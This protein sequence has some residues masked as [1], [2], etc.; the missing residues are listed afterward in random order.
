MPPEKVEKI[1]YHVLVASVAVALITAAVGLTLLYTTSP[2]A[3]KEAKYEG[4]SPAIIAELIAKR[5][6]RGILGLTAPTLIAG[7]LASI[8]AVIVHSAKNKD[9]TLLAISIILLT[10]L[11]TSTLVGLAVKN[12]SK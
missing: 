9:K 3:W 4:A 11:V 12:L 6:P 10:L 5:D 2:E 8:I 1:I 7:V